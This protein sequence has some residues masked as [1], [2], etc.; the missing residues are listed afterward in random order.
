LSILKIGS[1]VA[2]K[3]L[4]SVQ[5]AFTAACQQK[6]MGVIIVK[7]SVML[8]KLNKDSLKSLFSVPVIS[9]VVFILLMIVTSVCSA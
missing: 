7:E 3:P 6:A 5:R 4:S 9:L 2:S 8:N 1:I